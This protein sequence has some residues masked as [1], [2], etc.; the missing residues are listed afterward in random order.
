L[1]KELRIESDEAYELAHELA[2]RRGE[3][4]TEVILSALLKLQ[5]DRPLTE[6]WLE[7]GEQVRKMLPPDFLKGDPA[8]RLYDEQGLPQ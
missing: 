8:A 3:S 6:R 7:V 1:A 2:A 4:V 5:T